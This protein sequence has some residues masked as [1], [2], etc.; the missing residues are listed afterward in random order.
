M[1]L[2]QTRSDTH[3]K[4]IHRLSD[5]EEGR[6]IKSLSSFAK[7]Y[8]GMYLDLDKQISPD[9]RVEQ[10]ADR[11]VLGSIWKGFE[12]VLTQHQLPDPAEIG[13]VYA[14]DERLAIG[15][16]ALA[17]IDRKIRAHSC[18]IVEQDE[19]ILRALICLHYTDQNELEN[20]WIITLAQQRPELFA[21]TMMDYWL[22]IQAHGCTRFPGFRQVIQDPDY[23]TV[24]VTLLIPVLTH[25]THL[26]KKQFQKLLLTAFSERQT[27]TDKKLAALCSESLQKETDISVSNYACWLCAA[28]LLE[29]EKYD[30]RMFD[31]MGRTRE[32]ALPVLNFLVSVMEQ[33]KQNQL[34]ITSMMM[35]RLLHMIAPKF[36]PIKDRFGCFDENVEKVV[37]LFSWLNQQDDIEAALGYLRSVR[38]MRIYAEYFR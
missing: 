14:Q 2:E 38:V 31:Y 8:L 36:H 17:A 13:S 25:F 6:D 23:Y 20:P 18:N 24:L 35:A 1:D 12:V 34:H 22:A 28:Y 15:Y 3:E 29:P 30:Q 7:A 16:I 32:K 4:L 10:L 21:N 9:Q 27:L 37:W 5:L 33:D 26:D 11:D 19:E